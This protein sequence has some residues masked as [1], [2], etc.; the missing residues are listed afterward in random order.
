MPF[1]LR[2]QNINYGKCNF[3]RVINVKDGVLFCDLLCVFFVAYD[4]T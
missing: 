1:Y 2:E 4:V 3:D